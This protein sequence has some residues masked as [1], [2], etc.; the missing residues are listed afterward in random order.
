[1]LLLLLLAAPG[2]GSAQQGAR[3]IM[4]DTM[5]RM[6][7]AMGLFDSASDRRSGDAAP[8]D[9]MS[10]MGPLGATSWGSGF[11]KPSGSPFQDPSRAFAMGETMRQLYENMPGRDSPAG[12]GWRAPWTAS[13]LEGVW[14][15]RN[16]ELFI[17]QGSRFR[18]YSPGMQRVD[19]LIKIKG[20]RLALYNPLNERPQPFEFAE[21]RDR[22][23]MRDLAGQ[24]YLYR[25]L[26]LDGGQ[27]DAAAAEPSSKR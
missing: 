22:L 21:S 24:S 19:G 6:M 5:A 10:M 9:P 20:D 23:V 25:R 8:L 3:E 14:E 13:R 26:R 16:G 17:V 7:E 27:S 12:G 15:G 11:G 4:A 1:L 2:S 18:I